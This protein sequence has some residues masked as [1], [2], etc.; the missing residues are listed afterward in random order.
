MAVG[1]AM[2]YGG[3]AR[4]LVPAASARPALA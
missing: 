4:R 2:R 1:I 3:D